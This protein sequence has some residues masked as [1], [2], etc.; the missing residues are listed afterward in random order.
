MK[1][2]RGGKRQLSLANLVNRQIDAFLSDPTRNIEMSPRANKKQKEQ[3][4]DM[5]AKLVAKKL[6]NSDIKGAVRILS[7]NDLVLPYD[8]DTLSQLRSK[9]PAPHPES[10]FPNPPDSE[11]LASALQLTESQVLKAIQSFLGVLLGVA[12]CFFRNILTL[13][14]PD[15]SF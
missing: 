7:S 8:T 15:R 10:C 12:T 9:H 2:K 4:D 3:N 5:R 1:P 11:G 14:C 13:E 6:A